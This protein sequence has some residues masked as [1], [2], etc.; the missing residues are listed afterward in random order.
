MCD[1]VIVE[2]ADRNRS[3]VERHGLK[4]DV[5]GDVAS[6]ED[7]VAL[8][9]VPVA[10]GSPFLHAG[11]DDVGRS[12]GDARLSLGDARLSERGPSE[13]GT[14]VVLDGSFQAVAVGVVAVDAGR[15]PRPR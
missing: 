3:E 5:L 9:P 14:D 8:S 2:G 12:L 7:D 1:I 6:F 4:G 10:S 13:L 11:D 15:E